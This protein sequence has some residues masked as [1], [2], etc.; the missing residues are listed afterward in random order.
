[1]TDIKSLNLQEITGLLKEMGE[2][3]FAESRYSHG[4][5]AA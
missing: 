4:F 5:I 3:S 2:P 1:M